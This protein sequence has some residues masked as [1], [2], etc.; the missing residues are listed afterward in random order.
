[1]FEDWCKGYFCP[2]V[3]NDCKQNNL[4]FKTLLVLENTPG[5]LAALN[6]LCGN[7]KVV[8]VPPN[9]TYLPQPM[10]QGIISTSEAYYLRRTF[11]QASYNGE[12]AVSLTEFWKNFNIRQAFENICESWQE[13][14]D[15]TMRAA[16]KCLQPYCAN[17]LWLQK[18]S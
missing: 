9:S 5:H 2:A 3:E 6:G 1:L 14:V 13:V 7:V 16:W 11:A 17:D 4:A 10:D 18:S 15:N 12:G 8:F